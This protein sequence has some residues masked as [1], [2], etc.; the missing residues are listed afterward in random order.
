MIPDH[1][2]SKVAC[3]WQKLAFRLFEHHLAEDSNEM[4]TQ[5]VQILQRITQ[6]EARLAYL[7]LS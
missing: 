5:L 3:I 2:A 7:K 6:V 1:V 4:V